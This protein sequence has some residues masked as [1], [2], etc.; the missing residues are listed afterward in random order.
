MRGS[1]GG[2]LDEGFELAQAGRH[3][4]EG[5]TE[6]AGCG[7]GLGGERRIVALRQIDQAGVVAEIVWQEFRVA[8][9][10]EAL[11]HQGVELPSEKIG[12]IEGAGGGLGQGGKALLP[13]E[14][15]VAVRPG[16]AFDRFFLEHRIERAARAAI[17]IGHIDA[18]MR[19]PGFL[20]GVA[21]G[22]GDQ[23]WPVVQRRRQAAEIQMGQ[24]IRLDDGNDLARQRA[25]SDDQRALHGRHLLVGRHSDGARSMIAGRRGNGLRQAITRCWLCFL[26]MNRWAV[27]TATEASRQ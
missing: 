19:G 21:N 8:I 6:A 16:E 18:V 7:F 12:E 14:A 2:V 26:A 5:E 15:R 27:S 17:G 23:S 13:G 25:T 1:N 22:A 3:P 11:E 20:D 24:A 4:L 10:A 9:E